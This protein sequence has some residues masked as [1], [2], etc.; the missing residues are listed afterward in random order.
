M[1]KYTIVNPFIA[2][3]FKTV[4]EGAT[5]LEGAKKF[6]A[7]FSKILTNNVPSFSFTLQ[8]GENNKMYHFNVKEDMKDGKVNYTISEMALALSP[9]AINKL[10]NEVGKLQT[11]FGGRPYRYEDDL[12]DD[13]EIIHK[14]NKLN[15]KLHFNHMRGPIVYFK[16]FP[17]L[18]GVDDVYIPTFVVPIVPYMNINFS[19][20]FW[21]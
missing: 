15:K 21:G 17:G 8:E 6:W 7:E 10:T 14:F 5:P 3:T 4:Y 1:V 16:Y 18:Y 9:P 19:T 13:D 20:A 11:Q 2:G 12:S